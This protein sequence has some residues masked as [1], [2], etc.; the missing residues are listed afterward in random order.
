MGLGKDIAVF[1]AL[2]PVPKIVPDTRCS[3]HI[4]GM[5]EWKKSKTGEIGRI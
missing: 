1:S 2:S 4:C 5:N 3:V